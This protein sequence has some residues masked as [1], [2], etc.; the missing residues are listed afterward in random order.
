ML[1]ISDCYFEEKLQHVAGR[2]FHWTTASGKKISGNP[3]C[4]YYVI[5]K[6]DVHKAVYNFVE[7]TICVSL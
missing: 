7:E 2:G 3:M 1:Q 6:G 5:G 4:V